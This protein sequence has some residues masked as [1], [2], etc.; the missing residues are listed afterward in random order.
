VSLAAGAAVRNCRTGAAAETARAVVRAASVAVAA[1]GDLLKGANDSLVIVK[2]VVEVPRVPG[3]DSAVGT[4][5]RG[6]RLIQRR[7]EVP[8]RA[9]RRSVRFFQVPGL[10][11][12]LLPSI[13]PPRRRTIR[14]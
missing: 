9:T 13:A 11:G 3:G 10:A 6:E 4:C 1:A 8:P 5:R 14:H 12:A 2:Y 7:G